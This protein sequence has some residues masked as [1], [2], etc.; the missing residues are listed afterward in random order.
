[1]SVVKAALATAEW[2]EMCLG[3]VHASIWRSRCEREREP[4]VT[5]KSAVPDHVGS[6][7][8]CSVSILRAVWAVL[9]LHAGLLAWG[10]YIHS[11]SW[12]EYGHLPAGISHWHLGQFDLYRVNPPLVRMVA[13]APVLFCDPEIEWPGM[14]G[15]HSRPEW[16]AARS[17]V[18][19]HSEPLFWWFTLARWACI[20][21][22]LL[23]AWICYRWASGLYGRVAGFTAAVLWC[24]SPTVLGHGQLITPDVGAAAMGVAV[25][26]LLWRWLQLPSWRAAFAAG[27]VLGL[28]QLTKFTWI[29]LFGLWPI[30]WLVWRVGRG[31]A[32]RGRQ[33]LREAVQMLFLLVL[34]VYVINLGY[35]FEGSGTRL[36]QFRFVSRTLRQA[37]VESGGTAQGPVGKRFKESWCAVLPIPL[38]TNYMSGIDLQKRDFE[39]VSWSYLRGEWRDRGWWYYYLYGLAV[40]EPLGTW[41]LV[42]LAVWVTVAQRGYN[43]GWRDEMLLIVPAAAVLLLVSSQTGFSRHLRYV[44]PMYPLAIIW[45]S[46]VGRSI[47][48][49]DRRTAALTV[50]ALTASVGSSLFCFP[51]SL[52]YFNEAVGGPRRGGEH[53]LHSNFDWGQDLLLYRRWLEKHPERQPVGLAYA[54]PKS[55]IDPA[56]VGIAYVDIA[57]APDVESGRDQGLPEGNGPA[58]G[59]YAI[60]AGELYGR[61]GGYAHFR[62]L[63]P[64]ERVGYTVFV[65]HVEATPGGSGESSDKAPT[66]GN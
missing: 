33:W 4:A 51:H 3:R 31:R 59:W 25:G 57:S 1:M 2:S 61:H 48:L 47:E 40:K 11:P 45:I 54:L 46:K 62:E 8:A 23:G 24:F 28:A 30:L 19:T 38:P 50:M 13:G 41:V 26:Y 52:S 66:A 32:A 7:A 22:S 16:G 56:D 18:R 65:Y 29:I 15:P 35:G 20:A 53:L 21:F 6:R 55:L 60:F 39:R 17:M 42:A 12:D 34:A 27:V 58:P 36:G 49:R 63:E 14:S 64:V 44:L 37:T 5:T 10:A 43:R 9:A